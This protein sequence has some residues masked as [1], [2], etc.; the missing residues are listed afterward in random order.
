MSKRPINPSDLVEP[1]GFAHA[2]L[3]E[4][5]AQNTLYLAGQCGY[6]KLGKVA[7]PGDLVAQLDLAMANIGSVLREAEMVFSDLVQLNFFVCSRHDYATARREFGEVWRRHSD[8][9]FPAMAM[10]MVA[11]L[12]DVDALIEKLVDLRIPRLVLPDV[13]GRLVAAHS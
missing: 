2:W 8:R 5:K 6:D 7:A 3:V 4:S 12:Y 11:G 10:F 9:H 13:L 1:K